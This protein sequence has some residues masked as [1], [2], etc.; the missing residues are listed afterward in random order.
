M[1]GD[2]CS[3]KTTTLEGLH[4]AGMMTTKVEMEP[5]TPSPSPPIHSSLP[6]DHKAIRVQLNSIG[7]EGGSEYSDELPMSCTLFL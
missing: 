4:P 7:W 6:L 5:P 2:I 3:F 1:D